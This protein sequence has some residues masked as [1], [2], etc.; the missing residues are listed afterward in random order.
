MAYELKSF[1]RFKRRSTVTD[2]GLTQSI[3]QAI[4]ASQFVW[5]T[6]SGLA[7]QLGKTPDEIEGAL[8]ESAQ[9]V[10]SKIPNEDG[11]DLFTTVSLYKQKT[12]FLKRVLGAATN[13]IIP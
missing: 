1:S 7:K 4:V 2:T 11:E 6:K 13:S 8:L 12:P 9:F 5:R 10:K 3:V